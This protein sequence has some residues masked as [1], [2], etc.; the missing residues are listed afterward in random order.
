M[1]QDDRGGAPATHPTTLEGSPI[2]V[3]AVFGR[4]FQ[5]RCLLS[6]LSPGHSASQS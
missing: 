1:P 3:T 2:I 4:P 6:L 5:G